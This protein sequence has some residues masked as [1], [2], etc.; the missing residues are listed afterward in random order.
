MPTL[1]KQCIV[2][3]R[4]VLIE[5]TEDLL[6]GHTEII[7][8]SCSRTLGSITAAFA[9]N[10]KQQIYLGHF[11][12]TTDVRRRDTE[13]RVHFVECMCGSSTF[14][15]SQGIFLICILRNNYALQWEKSTMAKLSY[16]IRFRIFS[17]GRSFKIFQGKNQL[18]WGC[19]FK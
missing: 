13:N 4:A 12:Y 14:D 2:L 7:Q 1:L 19:F 5:I 11:I 17:E 8:T 18:V 10:P 9:R 15:I 16:A 6:T 3:S